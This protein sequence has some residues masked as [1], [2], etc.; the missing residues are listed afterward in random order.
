MILNY[1][2]KTDRRSWSEEQLKSAIHE[3]L[4]G[5]RVINSPAEP[6]MYL[7]QTT[8]EREVKQSR[9]NTVLLKSNFNSFFRRKKNK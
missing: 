9:T 6:F 8:L 4:D 7:K 5:K 1:T 3:V 2:R